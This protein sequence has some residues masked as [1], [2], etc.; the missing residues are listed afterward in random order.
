MK[1]GSALL[2]QKVSSYVRTH[3]ENG[4]SSQEIREALLKSGVPQDIIEKYLPS[5]HV[6]VSRSWFFVLLA[7]FVLFVVLTV[8]VLFHYLPSSSPACASDSNCPSGS[9]C[10]EGRCQVQ[11]GLINCQIESDCA[12]G[13]S[14]YKCLES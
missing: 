13:Y 12:Q 11:I 9:H 8:V 7:L 5:A 6:F 3:R 2:E 4:Y 10:S 1:E 14:C